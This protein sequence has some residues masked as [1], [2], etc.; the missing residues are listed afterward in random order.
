MGNAV[1]FTEKGTVSIEATA[2]TITD[3]R[4][5]VLFEITDSGIG[6]SLKKQKALFQAFQQADYSTTRRYGGTGARPPRFARIS[7][8]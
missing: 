5:V 8:S 1:K 2:D 4:I 6:I 7:W 3:D